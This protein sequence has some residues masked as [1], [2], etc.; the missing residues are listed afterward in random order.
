MG[1]LVFTF[2]AM[3]SGKS[4]A[5]LQFLSGIEDSHNKVLCLRPSVDTRDLVRFITARSTDFKYPCLT[6]SPV[7]CIAEFVS[8]FAVNLGVLS[9]IC[10]DEA[11]FLTKDQVE[12]L[13]WIADKGVD[14]YCFGLRTDSNGFLFDG[15][16]RLLE[17]A[18]ELVYLESECSCGRPAVVNAKFDSDGRFV[19]FSDN[20][21]D[22]GGDMK[23]TPVCRS[24]WR[25]LYK[26]FVK[27][28][29]ASTI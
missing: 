9:V 15:S 10:V 25:R 8:E 17:L 3:C 21:I 2:G 27:G 19:P 18:D 28:P 12:E 6:V 22:T 1:K 13:A 26:E 16:A 24:C 11:Q 14:V 7:D 5:L 4:T 20:V 29:A 23:Y